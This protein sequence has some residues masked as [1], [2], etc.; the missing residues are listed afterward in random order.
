MDSGYVLGPA[1]SSGEFGGRVPP[2]DHDP[3]GGVLMR[4]V[5]AALAL[6]LFAG[7]LFAN[8]NGVPHV[9]LTFGTIAFNEEKP[10]PPGRKGGKS[11][12]TP[13]LKTADPLLY[14][15][16]E[17]IAASTRHEYDVQIDLVRGNYYQILRWMRD[18]TI[19]GALVSPFLYQ[20]LLAD[21]ADPERQPLRLGELTTTGNQ[22]L[23]DPDA[24]LTECVEALVARRSA[25]CTF[26][27]VSHLST[28]GFIYP[29][30]RIEGI[31][32]NKYGLH[33]DSQIP[34]TRETVRSRLLERTHFTLWHKQLGG[35][36]TRLEFSYS[37]ELYNRQVKSKSPTYVRD[38]KWA[39]LMP[40]Q[41]AFAKDLIAISAI[42]SNASVIRSILDANGTHHAFKPPRKLDR[43]R[44][45]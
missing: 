15:Y 33:L 5:V 9:R 41:R 37:N 39:P 22:P 38:E 18:G 4:T 20:I 3:T 8:H 10:L 29:L 28:T 25:Q 1:M 13:Q 12:G 30:A 36:G 43:Y 45:A 26:Q 35:V 40:A 6:C 21:S 27:F 24:V 17:H 16:L 19:D 11:G 31:L 42:S 2:T 23:D 7:P 32:E 14:A 34:H 44:E